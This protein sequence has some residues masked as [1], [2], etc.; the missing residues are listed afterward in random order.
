[1]FN[2]DA[3]AEAELAKLVVSKRDYFSIRE[4]DLRVDKTTCNLDGSSSESDNFSRLLILL[5]PWRVISATKLAEVVHACAEHLVTVGDEE[6]VLA[7]GGNI[8]HLH[9]PCNEVAD[10]RW[11]IQI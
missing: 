11:R 3:R 6:G 10:N 8:N 9:R 7:T 1:M 4:Q 5:L 2:I